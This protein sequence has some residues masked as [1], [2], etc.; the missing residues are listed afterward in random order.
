MR[1]A[2]KFQET[3]AEHT[4]FSAKSFS[5][6]QERHRQEEVQKLS[7]D[8]AR[9]QITYQLNW[10]ILDLTEQKPY[11][12]ILLVTEEGQQRFREGD[13]LPTPRSMMEFKRSIASGSSSA[14]S[15]SHEGNIS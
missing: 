5:E 10:R 2:Q 4:A 15:G 9:R 1:H 6:W 12:K 8:D 14:R 3:E 7:M 11:R 13:Y